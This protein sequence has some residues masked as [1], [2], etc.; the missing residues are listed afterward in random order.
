MTGM[1]RTLTALS[2]LL[3]TLNLAAQL[4][5]GYD[6]LYD[7]ETVRALK[8]HVGFLA[9]PRLE[10]RK[11]GSVGEEM[12]ADYVED[13]LTRYGVELISPGAGG[14]F[15]ITTDAG[16]T[17]TSRNVIGLIP[18]YDRSL[19]DKYIVIGAHLDGR[20]TDTLTVDGVPRERI[21]YGA[22]ADAS[23]TAMLL[24][25]ARLLQT[26]RVLL[27][28]SV[29][30]V[31][32]GASGER[33]AGSFYFLNRSF[34]DIDAVEAMICLERLG[35]GED[36]FCAY[37]ASNADMSALVR[38]LNGELQPILPTLTT[39]EPFPSDMRAFYAA[40]V[41][42]VLFSGG[43]TVGYAAEKDLPAQLDYAV[44]E[45]ELEYIYGFAVALAN[46][47]APSFLPSQGKKPADA[48]EAAISYFD[49]DYRPSFL[50]STDPQQ[51]LDRWVYA[52]LKYPEEAVERGLSGRVMVS[53]IIDEKGAV[54]D[55]KVT[56]GVDPLLDREAVRVVAASPKW[57]PGRHRGKKVRTAIT[58]PVE[59]RLSRK[60]TFGI[61]K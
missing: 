45:R 5:R 17:L 26:N 43:R 20:G 22:N 21:Y 60:S 36:G 35:G 55:V 37:T 19:K 47:P 50:G 30:L 1:K 31:D 18:G 48:P 42:S 34:S 14:R 51:F 54:T 16:D 9:S 12:A 24:E 52:Y 38:S 28:R 23:G 33:F 11:A 61:K 53:F 10:G 32:F 57:K 27:R 4:R 2:L 49:I 40:S 39:E 8:E 44:M 13:L 46:G 15:G 3:L 58:I 7:S 59:F 25:L 56:R 29:L 6:E 41:P